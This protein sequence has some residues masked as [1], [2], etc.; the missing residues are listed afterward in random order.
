MNERMLDF[1]APDKDDILRPCAVILS[2]GTQGKLREGSASSTDSLRSLPSSL[3]DS[4]LR[5]ALTLIEFLFGSQDSPC[6]T[7]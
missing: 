1:R 4:S 2:G 6:G 3:S 5:S 7:E